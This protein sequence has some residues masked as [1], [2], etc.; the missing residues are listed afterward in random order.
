MESG[1]NINREQ[2]SAWY[3]PNVPHELHGALPPYED[4]TYTEIN[5][6]P[7]EGQSEITPPSHLYGPDLSPPESPLQLP[8][9]AA[10]PYSPEWNEAVHAFIVESGSFDAI[11]GCPQYGEKDKVIARRDGKIYDVRDQGGET[12]HI[13]TE[14]TNEEVS[15][16]D[17][18]GIDGYAKICIPLLYPGVQV[19]THDGKGT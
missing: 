17:V 16:S 4:Y 11:P 6:P 13:L 10:E 14:I 7:Y 15:R 12:L 9:I 2:G 18:R 5:M 19:T 1:S 3:A 8:E